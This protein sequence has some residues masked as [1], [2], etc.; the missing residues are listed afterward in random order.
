MCLTKKHL[1]RRTFLRGIGAAVSLPLLDAMVPAGKALAQTAAAP[2]PK[3]GFFYFPHGAVIDRWRPT[4]TGRN[5][6]LPQILAPFKG[7]EE[8]MT[9]VSGLRNKAAEGAG[10]HSV[11]PGTWLGCTSPFLPGLDKSLGG[12]SAEGPTRNSNCHHHFIQ[13]R[14]ENRHQCNRQYQSGDCQECID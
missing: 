12:K 11:N 14:A 7:F 6:E 10:V 5:F 8:H 1:P 3:T 9:V 13:A 4:T 2:Q